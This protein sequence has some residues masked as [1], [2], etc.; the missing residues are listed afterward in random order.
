[1]RYVHSD[2]DMCAGCGLCVKECPVSAIEM[3]TD[4]YGFLYPQI[5]EGK[6]IGCNKCQEVCITQNT[7]KLTI[8]TE[9]YAFVKKD[10]AIM[11]SSSG[12]F[13]ATVAEYII[14][15]KHGIVIGS[16]IDSDFNIRHIAISDLEQIELLQGS[17]YVQSDILGM[18]DLVKKEV[19]DRYV[20][21]SGTPCQCSAVRKYVGKSDRLITLEVIC[22]GV[23]NNEM[24]KEYL[25]TLGIKDIEKFVFR[26][27]KQGWSFNSRVY[28][29]NR[30]IKLPH[31]L[32][33]YMSLFLNGEIYRDSCYK[34]PYA[35]KERGSDIVIGDYW[36]IIKNSKQ[37][38]KSINIEKGVSCVLVNTGI[39]RE[40]YDAVKDYNI[41]IKAEY[42][43]ICL[44]NGPLNGP[45]V[46]ESGMRN[47]VL[48][49]Y[50][51]TRKWDG[52]DEY[53]KSQM[54]HRMVWVMYNRLPVRVQNLV[55]RLLGKR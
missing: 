20:L 17:K 40:L 44:E 48:S 8:P 26:D 21:F 32:S 4:E 7:G 38:S 50:K 14:K 53:F 42:E 39:G 33:S 47:Q 35:R 13:F 3:V 41:S 2:K 52:V 27:K 11:K 25:K 19:A 6:C 34:C 36:G 10:E 49:I 15:E 31:R 37:L 45:S 43:E 1:M 29:K 24:F 22:H 18:Y 9:S 30:Q 16:V 54:K 28:T 51:D 12:G 23:P 55:R 46:P 5:D